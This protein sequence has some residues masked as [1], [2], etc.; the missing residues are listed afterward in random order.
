MPRKLKRKKSPLKPRSGLKPGEYVRRSTVWVETID[1]DTAS[2]ELYQTDPYNVETHREDGRWDATIRYKGDKWSIPGKVLDQ[3]VR[4][5]ES[6]MAEAKR[7]K[8]LE[9]FERSHAMAEARAASALNE[10]EAERA[11]DLA[12]L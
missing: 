10:A 4:H 1:M 12:G 2:I 5:R 8:G 7:R 6:I 9:R 3:L 11:I